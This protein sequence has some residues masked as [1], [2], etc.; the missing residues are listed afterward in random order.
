MTNDP[1]K[2]EPLDY[3]TIHCKDTGDLELRY[4]GEPFPLNGVMDRGSAR[5]LVDMLNQHLEG[6][7]KC[8]RAMVR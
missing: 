2:W 1:E 3:M 5:K 8:V 6:R 4:T 7:C